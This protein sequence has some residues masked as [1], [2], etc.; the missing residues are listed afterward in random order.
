MT[1]IRLAASIILIR[2]GDQNIEVYLVKRS[3]R[4]AFMGGLWAFPGGTVSESDYIPGADACPLVISNCARRELF[5][6]TGVLLAA[7][8]CKPLPTRLQSIRQDLLSGT[9][10]SD[11][12]RLQTGLDHPGDYLTPVCEMITPAM[13]PVRYQT[14][15]LLARLPNECVPAVINGE[16]T[17]GAFFRPAEAI[18]LWEEGHVQIAPPNLL[19]LRIMAK[20]GLAGFPVAAR[21]ETLKLADGALHPVYF[22]PGIFLAALRTQTL[23]PATTTNTLIVGNRDLYIIDPATD[24]RDEQSRLFRKMDEMIAAGAVFKGI[25]L[26][27]HHSD[28]TGAVKISSLKY[29]LQVRAHPQCYARLQPGYITGTPLQDGELISL[30]Q[31]PDGTEGW[32][33]RVLYTPGHAIDHVAFL[34]NK[35][36][37]AIVG[38][39]LST[40]STI[41]I[42]P[43]EGHMA[44]YLQSLETLLNQPLRTLFPAHGPPHPDGST[45]IRQFLDHRRQREE[46]IVKVMHDSVSPT[47]LGELLPSVY[48]DVDPAMHRVAERSLL[49]GLIKLEEEGRCSRNDAGCWYLV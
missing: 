16:L 4:L 39:M 30:G 8:S 48:A 32:G 18:R 40:V 14:S 1:A 28:H 19:L 38:D 17:E 27:H 42:D 22:S 25:L 26:T 46:L 7:P 47:T 13:S 3:S 49:A 5:E 24:E 45:L 35:Y 41:L 21:N 20:H 29:N 6:E 31:A 15:F 10:D 23:P 2:G 43:P 36:N 12:T 9:G 33:L 44:T 37:A 34:D 11:W